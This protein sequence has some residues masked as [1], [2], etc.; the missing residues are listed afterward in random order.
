VKEHAKDNLFKMTFEV[1]GKPAMTVTITPLLPITVASVNPCIIAWGQH[2]NAYLT[3]GLEW[4]I[5]L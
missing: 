3:T 1:V 4:R 2:G 5:V